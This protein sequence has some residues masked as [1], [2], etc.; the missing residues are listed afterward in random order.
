LDH[1]GTQNFFDPFGSGQIEQG[2]SS[3]KS[4]APEYCDNHFISP[5]AG[6]SRRQKQ[7]NQSAA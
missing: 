4:H 3:L 7:G 1:I 6:S 2:R 5:L